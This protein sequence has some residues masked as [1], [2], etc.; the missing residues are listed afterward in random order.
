VT[1]FHSAL[2]KC[3]RACEHYSALHATIKNFDAGDPYVLTAGRPEPHAEGLEYIITVGDLPNPP[4]NLSLWVPEI[5]SR[6]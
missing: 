4:P 1:N 3:R 5:R 2:Q 6:R